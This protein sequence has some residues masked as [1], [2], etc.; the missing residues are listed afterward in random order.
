MLFMTRLAGATAVV[1]FEVAISHFSLSYASFVAEFCLLLFVGLL[2]LYNWVLFNFVRLTLV[3]VKRLLN[4][5]LSKKY[6][7]NL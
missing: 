1:L 3:S 6:N 2:H 7:T 5:K 4:F